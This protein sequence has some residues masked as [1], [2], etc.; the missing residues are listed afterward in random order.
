MNRYQ[1]TMW[2]IKGFAPV[3]ATVEANSRLD[4][5]SDTPFKRKAMAQ[6]CNK[7]GWSKA[8]LVDRYGYTSYKVRLA[9][10]PMTKPQG[11]PE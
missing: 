2:S 11:L 6:I 4:F 10:P 8:D 3:A 1:F 7:R 5:A 9:P